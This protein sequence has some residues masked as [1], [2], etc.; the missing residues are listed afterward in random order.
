MWKMAQ[1]NPRMTDAIQPTPKSPC[2][3]LF[4]AH[5]QSSRNRISPAYMLPKSRSECDS[6][7]EMY[8]TIWNR[9]LAGISAGCEP[10]GAKK[11]SCSHPPKPLTV[12]AKKI[13]STKM[14][15]DSAK[16]VLTSAVGTYLKPCSET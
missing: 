3:E 11:S 6:V 16:V 12:I 14:E 4:A 5:S 15:M 1:P 13:V 2:S 7:F 10:K 9:K 8:S